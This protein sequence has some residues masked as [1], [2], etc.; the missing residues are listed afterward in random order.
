MAGTVKGKIE[1]YLNAM[2]PTWSYRDHG[3]AVFKNLYD[4]FSA[5]PNMTQIARH[6]GVG[7][8]AANVNYW[9]QTN[10]FLNN[11]WFVFRMNTAVQN[12]LYLGT[13][14]Y[15]WYVLAQWYRGDVGTFGASPGNPGLIDAGTGNPS[16]S[17]VSLQFAIGIDGDQN[18]WKGSGTLGTNTKGTPVWGTPAGGTGSL[19]WP[20][21][22]SIGGVHA[23]DKQNTA[24]MFIQTGASTA[25]CHYLADDDSFVFLY[26]QGTY[27]YSGTFFGQ[28]VPRPD[29]TIPYPYVMFGTGS[30]LLPTSRTRAYGG[31]AGDGSG[32]EGTT[33][34][35][36]IAGPYPVTDGL[37]SVM[38]DRYASMLESNAMLSPN[39][40]FLLSLNDEF[41][42]S[43][44]MAEVPSYYGWLGQVE[45]LRETFN[46]EPMARKS[47][48]T[49]AIMSGVQTMNS[50]KW[51][52]PW[53]PAAN[54]GHGTFR[55]GI[56]F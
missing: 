47:D 40:N 15:P 33:N 19:V 49:Q 55:E 44:I 9:D 3:Q 54:M 22:N 39:R 21:S 31:P 6:G 7:G 29:L 17:Q 14:T 1:C 46:I 41:P 16:Y 42:I 23:T 35:G 45:F 50:T 43:V 2:G 32:F 38:T 25:R 34:I 51:V 18:P 11:A 36:G 28:Y 52:V 13:R 4:F 26:E 27:N 24:T 5:H 20:R 53:A 37:R 56:S 30:A 12:P 48:G 10:P 8:T